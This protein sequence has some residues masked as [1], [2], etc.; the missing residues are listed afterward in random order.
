MKPVADSK[1]QSYHAGAV[2]DVA[3][4]C[5]HVSSQAVTAIIDGQ[6]I[7]HHPTV[8][9]GEPSYRY[10]SVA[11]RQAERQSTVDIDRDRI[12]FAVERHMPTNPSKRLELANGMYLTQGARGQSVI[13]GFPGIGKTDAI[14]RLKLHAVDSDDLA[15]SIHPQFFELKRSSQEL[16]HRLEEA[17]LAAIRSCVERGSFVLTNVRPSNLVAHGIDC[18]AFL[19]VSTRSIKARLVD[20]DGPQC[21]ILHRVDSWFAEEQATIRKSS[22]VVGFSLPDNAF[23]SQAIKLPQKEWI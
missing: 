6:R 9:E 12:G 11:R 14:R 21:P 23:L 16:E 2:S 19:P 3:R 8:E 1:C 4:R 15:L 20:R 18:T 22:R 13:Y 7:G 5:L 10:R 17:L